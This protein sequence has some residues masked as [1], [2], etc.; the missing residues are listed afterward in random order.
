[1]PLSDSTM[2]SSDGAYSGLSLQDAV[3]YEGA[4]A[5]EGEIRQFDSKN[6]LHL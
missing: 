3:P 5:L 6:E 4:I 2:L 1:M